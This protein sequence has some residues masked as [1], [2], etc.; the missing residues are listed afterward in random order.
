MLAL[1]AG[2]LAMGGG[3]ALV[4]AASRRRTVRVAVHELPAKGRRGPVR[5][6]VRYDVAEG[7]TLPDREALRD[8]LGRVTRAAGEGQAAVLDA[9]IRE[10]HDEWGLAIRGVEVEPA[11]AT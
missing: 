6:R 5:V 10:A 2:A 3:L 1:L 11:D 7:R 9:L 4:W 8:L